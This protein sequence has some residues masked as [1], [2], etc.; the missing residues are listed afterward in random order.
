MNRLHWPVTSLGE[1]RR[2]AIRLQGCP[3]AC[4][5]CISPGLQPPEL[6]TEVEVERLV[7]FICGV[8][9]VDGVTFTGGEPFEQY[10]ALVEACSRLK[11]RTTLDLL[12]FTGYTVE[13]LQR[14]HPRGEY[15]GVLDGLVDGPSSRRSTENCRWRGSTNQRYF[16]IRDG[17]PLEKPDGFATGPASA[18]MSADGAL[19][20][21]G[22]PGAGDLDRI[23]AHL[24]SI[25]IAVQEA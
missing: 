19:F 2:I 4:P 9:G 16:R 14:S 25:G 11:Q 12:V 8:E 15:L 21:A 20:I 23:Y 1:G 6:G 10:P 13:E 18:S 5:G 22:I 17:V 7:D 3:R 24:R